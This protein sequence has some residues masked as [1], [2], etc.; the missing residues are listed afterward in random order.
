MVQASPS[1]QLTGTEVQVGAPVNGSGWQAPPVGGVEVQAPV[2]GL[3]TS[4]VQ[5][6]LSLHTIGVPQ[7]PAWQ[8]FPT[9]QALESSHG[10]P[11]GAWVDWHS[12]VV[13]LQVS[14][15]QGLPSSQSAL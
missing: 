14:V 15:V 6:L 11:F 9:V 1:S 8:V 7:V 5:G 4:V 12:P 2:V 3:R 10:V 13:G